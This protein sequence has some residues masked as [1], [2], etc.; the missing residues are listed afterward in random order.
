MGLSALLRPCFADFMSSFVALIHPTAQRDCLKSL[1]SPK[2]EAL[3][4]YET[5][6]RDSFR[7]GVPTISVLKTPLSDLL[8][9]LRR[10][11]L[12]STRSPGAPYPPPT[13]RTGAP[14]PQH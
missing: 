14:K 11:V 5:E 10:G 3:E 7:C 4:A 13:S 1:D 9:S 2:T 12:G 8:N 6:Q